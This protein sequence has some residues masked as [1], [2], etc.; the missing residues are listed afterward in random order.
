VQDL[1]GRTL[2]GAPEWVAQLGLEYARPVGSS[3][4]LG[5]TFNTNYSS[6]YLYVPELNPNGVQGDFATYDA[7]LR[8]GAA[9]RF[10]ELALIGRNLS[11]EAIVTCGQ[12]AGTVIPGVTSDAV[13][14]V[15]R[16]RQV[17]LQLTVRPGGR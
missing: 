1:R 2:S 5:F 7:S 12:D 17:L 14:F 16:S 3:L 4:E 10:W 13:A 15:L 6:D 11:N 9:D 8:V